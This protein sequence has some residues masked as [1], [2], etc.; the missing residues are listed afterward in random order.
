M[1]PLKKVDGL[2]L[3]DVK[4]HPVWE[5]ALDVEGVEGNDETSVRPVREIPVSTLRGRVVGTRVRLA[6]GTSVWALLGNVDE[7]SARRTQH[8]LQVTVWRGAKAFDLARYQDSDY[9]RRGPK[10]LARFLGLAIDDVFP[11]AYDLRAVAK[12]GRPAA[13]AGTIPKEPPEKLSG[14]ELTD[15]AIAGIRRVSASA[16]PKVT[17]RKL[18][19]SAPASRGTWAIG[20]LQGILDSHPQNVTTGF[21]K[22]NLRWAK[23]VEVEFWST[24]AEEAEAVALAAKVRALIRR[25][26][27]APDGSTVADIV[28]TDRRTGRLY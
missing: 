8:F 13:L 21:G 7:R 28:I 6:N 14:D 19:I 27:R 17:T 23:R 1:K 9:A 12:K 11:L 4:A 10:A 25:R 18:T 20:V 3:R 2:T 26:G 5:Y 15:L 16:T 22:G 24:K